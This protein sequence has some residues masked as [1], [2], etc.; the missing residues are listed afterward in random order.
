MA[1][2]ALLF[3]AAF[4]FLSI[5]GTTQSSFAQEP[6]WY[7]YVVARG[8][9]RFVIENTPI[10]LR[11]YRPFHFYGNTV[12]RIHYRGNPMPL[13]R[14]LMRGTSVW[15]RRGGSAFPAAR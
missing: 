7:P 13:P 3:V 4:A 5:V 11:P 1:R 10:E 2:P 14:D 8:Q 12:R 6:T 9:D 15:F